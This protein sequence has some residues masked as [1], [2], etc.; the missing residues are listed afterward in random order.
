MS[1]RESPLDGV[2]GE[3]RTRAEDRRSGGSLPK[4]LRSWQFGFYSG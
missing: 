3:G 4:S 2:A 1:Q